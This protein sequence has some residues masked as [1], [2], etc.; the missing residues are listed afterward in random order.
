MDL[1]QN[2][3]H[4]NRNR[5][6]AGLYVHIPFCLRKCRYCDF[7]STTDMSLKRSFMGAL[8]HEMQLVRSDLLKFDTLY[9]GGGTP[10]LLDATSIRRIIEVAR[11]TFNILDDVEI[12]L[13][14]NPGTITPEQLHGYRNAGVNRIHIGVQ[15]FDPD[16]LG[17]LGRMHSKEEA[18]LAIK[19]VG[20]AGFH[21]TGLDLM[22]GI[23]GQSKKS[24]LMDLKRAVEFKPQHLSCYMLTCESGT[25]LDKDRKDGRFAPQ[26]DGWLSDLF[27][28][29]LAFLSS[30]KYVQYEISSFARSDSS[31]A[32]AIGFEHN[33]SRHNRKYWSFAP[34]IGLGPSA[35]SFI[36]PQRRWNHASV[37][38][39]IQ[40]LA[41]GR[42]PI[43]GKEMLS[44][45]QLMIEAISL[46][47][48]QTEG[49]RLDR[50]EKRFNVNFQEMFKEVITDLG[51]KGFIKCSE[52]HCV[53]TRKGMLF[54]DSITSAIVLRGM[55]V[56]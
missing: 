48:R 42:L 25:P 40:D 47:L 4:V 44:K 6:R 56:G 5:Q 15:S 8:T 39:Y 38:K 12:T 2:S 54:L 24:W 36:E 30:Q 17:F 43:E 16:N 19:W 41:A 9:I 37:K 14:V 1:P 55:D 45:E 49:I 51:E 50:F 13:E 20:E 23:P 28:T 31:Q 26:T 32:G 18:E 46:G 3:S 29:T 11:H 34:Y 33:V 10:S 53:L 52:N 21:N 22:S 35:H 7:Y 27:D